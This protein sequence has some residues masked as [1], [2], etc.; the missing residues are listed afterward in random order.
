MAV[1]LKFLSVFAQP[2]ALSG[3]LPRQ[4]L[5]NNGATETNTIWASPRAL[6]FAGP[7]CCAKKM[8]K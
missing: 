4:L 8:L 5:D 7:E 2:R 6:G 3:Q 1:R